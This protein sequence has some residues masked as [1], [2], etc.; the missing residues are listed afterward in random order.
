[1]YL[2]RKK[3]L[4]KKKISPARVTEKKGT[5][6]LLSSLSVILSPTKLL[7]AMNNPDGQVVKEPDER[8]KINLYTWLKGER[9]SSTTSTPGLSHLNNIN[10][11]C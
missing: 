11:L 1:M 3:R 7:T 6:S 10:K 9:G 8:G 5:L 4:K 2:E